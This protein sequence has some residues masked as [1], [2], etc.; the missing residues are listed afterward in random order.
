MSMPS[1]RLVQ[2]LSTYCHNLNRSGL[3]DL[4]TALR[5]GRY[6]WFA[7]E[8]AGAI[9]AGALTPAVWGS[10][11]GTE[12]RAGETAEQAVE[13][14]LR[15]V[16]DALFDTALS[17]RPRVRR[18]IG[19]RRVQPGPRPLLADPSQLHARRSLASRR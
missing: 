8:F 18:R 16:W 2:I 10:V 1:V 12:P 13:R 3:A 14:E 9:T 6:P 15:R 11:T 17:G 19:R 5:T 4:E 7:E